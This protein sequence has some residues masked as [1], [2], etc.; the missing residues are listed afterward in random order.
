MRHEVR[1]GA[2]HKGEEYTTIC[3]HLSCNENP[4]GGSDSGLMILI[5]FSPSCLGFGC[6]SL[7]VAQVF[8]GRAI[9]R[10]I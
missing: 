5:S 9:F 10:K 4:Q 7:S 6:I 2:L 8:R 1:L 3:V